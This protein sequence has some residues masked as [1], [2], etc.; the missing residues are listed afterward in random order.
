MIGYTY[1]GMHAHIYNKIHSTYQHYDSAFRIRDSLIDMWKRSVIGVWPA[2]LRTAREQYWKIEKIDICI[3]TLWSENYYSHADFSISRNLSLLRYLISRA[4]SRTLK[5]T[6]TVSY[7]REISRE[8]GRPRENVA[9][10]SRWRSTRSLAD[11]LRRCR[12]HIAKRVPFA[13]GA[14]ERRSRLRSQRC[15]NSQFAQSWR[16]KIH[17]RKSRERKN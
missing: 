3:S 14:K 10:E 5:L 13:L 12:I 11:L 15:Q 4:I 17:A 2:R 16:A 9:G 7:L 1:L 8:I 6:Q